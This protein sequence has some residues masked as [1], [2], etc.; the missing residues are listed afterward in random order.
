LADK[1]DTPVIARAIAESRFYADHIAAQNNG[2]G[3]STL[4][5][6][7]RE[8]GLD[9]SLALAVRKAELELCELDWANDL[10]RSLKL[11]CQF[12]GRAAT[13]ADTTDPRVISAIGE[14]IAKLADAHSTLLMLGARGVDAR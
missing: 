1:H 7:R 9:S 3:L 10:K 6:Y 11:A 5:R 14:A 8:M 13:S 2:I 12:I 4:R